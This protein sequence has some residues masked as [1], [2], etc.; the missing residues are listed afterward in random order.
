MDQKWQYRVTPIGPNLNT[1]DIQKMLDQAGDDGWELV[2]VFL[3][4]ISGFN[5]F[6][7]KKQKL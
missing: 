2:T 6:I 5:S 3:N 1:A 7:F 4:A